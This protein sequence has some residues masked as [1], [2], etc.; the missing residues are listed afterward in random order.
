MK[1][2]I[3]LINCGMGSGYSGASTMFGTVNG[4]DNQPNTMMEIPNLY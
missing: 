4:I 2:H 3:K 1:P